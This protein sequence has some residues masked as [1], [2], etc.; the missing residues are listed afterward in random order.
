MY[1]LFDWFVIVRKHLIVSHN[2]LY[3]FPRFTLVRNYFGKGRF[4]V[5]PLPSCKGDEG[6]VVSS[7]GS[8]IRR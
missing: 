6:L 7:G 8:S 1:F 5:R 2:R 4:I 3:S